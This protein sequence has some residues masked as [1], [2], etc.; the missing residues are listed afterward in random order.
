MSGPGEAAGRK[1]PEA[2]VIL[3]VPRDDDTVIAGFPA[4]GETSFDEKSPYSTPLTLRQHR[5]GSKPH[6]AQRAIRRFYRNRLKRMCPTTASATDS[7][8]LMMK[9]GPAA[10]ASHADLH[11]F[12]NQ[13]Q[14]CT[15]DPSRRRKAASNPEARI[16]AM[17]RSCPMVKYPNRYPI[18]GSGS[19]KNSR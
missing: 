19:L 16:M 5:H 2:W 14:D 18:C 9:D 17:H 7:T 13:R 10:C 15:L 1:K 4:L 11:R 8:S 6:R 12:R 3:R